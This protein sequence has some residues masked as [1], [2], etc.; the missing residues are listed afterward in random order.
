[1]WTKPRVRLN[2][3]E[4]L[5]AAMAA[6]NMTQSELALRANVKQ[7]FVS[8]LVRGIALPNVADIANIA[9]ALGTTVDALIQNPEEAAV[10]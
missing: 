2:L 3:A 1:M 9:E 10:A 6:G 7:V 8:R 4:N 5:S